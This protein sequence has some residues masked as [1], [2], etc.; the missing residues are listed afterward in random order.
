MAF[1]LNRSKTA[2]AALLLV[3]LVT[4][5][6]TPF[7]SSETT[8]SARS[9]PDFSVTSF[10]LDGAGSVQDGVDV[11]VENAT[12]VARIVVSNTGSAAGT[13]VVSLYHQ[14]SSASTRTLVSAIEIGPIAPSTSHIPVLID[15]PASPG[16]DQRLFAETFS[17]ADPNS[18][19][20]EM[21]IDFDVRF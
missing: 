17:L 21:R 10:T 14:G 11:Y 12:H 5:I 19:N 18:G 1:L 3:M 6:A 4:P 8:T 9:S 13:V 15:W 7:A 2:I 16:N 20:N